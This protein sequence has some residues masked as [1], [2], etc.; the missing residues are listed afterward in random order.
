MVFGTVSIRVVVGAMGAENIIPQK[1]C[2]EEVKR[3]KKVF[4][5]LKCFGGEQS[6]GQTRQSKIR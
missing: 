4:I 6:V 3:T 1:G 5:K 2:I